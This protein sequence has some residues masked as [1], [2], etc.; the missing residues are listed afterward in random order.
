MKRERAYINQ[1]KKNIILS[2]IVSQDLKTDKKKTLL[3]VTLK[4]SILC[5]YLEADHSS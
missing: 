4:C 1:R 5:R 3:V 2:Y